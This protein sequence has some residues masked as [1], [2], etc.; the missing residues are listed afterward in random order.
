VVAKAAEK[1]G[2]GLLPGV[3]YTSSSKRLRTKGMKFIVLPTSNTETESLA[4]VSHL[5][6][7]LCT[8]SKMPR[9]QDIAKMCWH[10]KRSRCKLLIEGT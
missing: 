10:R 5:H 1:G 2:H 7:C 3:R 8:V 9:L 6:L 4:V